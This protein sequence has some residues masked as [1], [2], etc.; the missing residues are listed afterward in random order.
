MTMK[1]YPSHTLF[2][3][4]QPEQDG[5]SNWTPIGV[6]FT[7]KDGSF[8]VYFDDGKPAPA[9]ARL[10]LRKRKPKAAP[11]TTEGGAQ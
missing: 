4:F 9:G 8:A 6:A 3:V 10:V 2:A 11:A 1:T 7:N 5:P